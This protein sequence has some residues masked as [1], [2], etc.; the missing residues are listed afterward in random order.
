[1]F[2]IL[3]TIWWVLAT[4]CAVDNLVCQLNTP[5]KRSFSWEIASIRVT[6]GH[7]CVAFFHWCKSAQCPERLCAGM[8]G[9]YQKANQASQKFLRALCFCF[10]LGFPQEWTWEPNRPF[11]SL[12]CFWLVFCHCDRGA[13]LDNAHPCDQSSHRGTEPSHYP[14]KLPVTPHGSSPSTGNH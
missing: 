1:M 13:N 14:T 4:P 2:N 9:L 6:C 11:P 8:P 7:I 12:S 10:C 5:R 3:F